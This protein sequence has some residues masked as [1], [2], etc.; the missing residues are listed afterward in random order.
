MLYTTPDLFFAEVINVVGAVL[1]Y[2]LLAEKKR[3]GWLFY[4]LS[5]IALIYVLAHKESWMTVI[6]QSMMGVLAIKNFFYFHRPE[7]R[8]HRP[9]EWL[10]LLV[11]LASFSMIGQL[12]GKA[13]SEIVL[14]TAIIAKTILLGKKNIL[15]WHF[16]VLQ[17]SLSVVFGLY[18]EIYLYVLKGAFFALHGIWGYFRWRKLA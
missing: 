17:Q 6:N 8:W 2:G 16:Q 10:T 12:D 18:R 4:L 9:F 11:F 15:G 3:A 14:W 7:S 13:I 5:S 1:T